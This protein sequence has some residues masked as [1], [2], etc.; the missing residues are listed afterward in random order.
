MS[1]QPVWY[2]TQPQ[3]LPT[4]PRPFRFDRCSG[5]TSAIFRRVFKKTPPWEHRC[6]PHDWEYHHGGPNYLRKIADAKYQK[7][8]IQDCLTQGDFPWMRKLWVAHL[9]AWINWAGVT[10]GGWWWIPYHARW[11]FGYPYPERGPAWGAWEA[12]PFDPSIPVE[13]YDE[14]DEARR[15]LQHSGD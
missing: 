5:N 4:P 12:P 9:I 11:G 8:I 6:L 10:I 1:Q 7:G 2:R 3:I 14:L 15:R 13:E